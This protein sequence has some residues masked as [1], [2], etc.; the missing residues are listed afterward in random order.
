M[1]IATFQ[2]E[3]I[4]K[5]KA[6]FP[7]DSASLHLYTHNLLV[8]H[9]TKFHPTNSRLTFREAE[10][11]D[12]AVCR[13]RGYIRVEYIRPILTLGY[14][15]ELVELAKARENGFVFMDELDAIPFEKAIERNLLTET[16]IARVKRFRYP[17][18][19]F[20]VLTPQEDIDDVN[21]LDER[22]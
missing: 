14:G 5:I 15:Q 6:L 18:E 13:L 8:R 10:I 2:V 11:G 22:I 19:T 20:C 4:E 12:D 17:G 7:E 9:G 16:V 3:F 1:Q 21:A